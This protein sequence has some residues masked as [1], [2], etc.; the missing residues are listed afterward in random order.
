MTLPKSKKHCANLDA[1]SRI[2]Q[3]PP[4][5]TP[6]SPPAIPALVTAPIPRHDRA[7]LGAQRRVGGLG[8]EGKRLLRVGL[9]G[10]QRRGLAGLHRRRLFGAK[11]AQC[12]PPENII[13]D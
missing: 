2:L 10:T 11:E 9:G 4:S 3:T 12:Q 5:A 6:A 1:R 7:A 13:R 8:R